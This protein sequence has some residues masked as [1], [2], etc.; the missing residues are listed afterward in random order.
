MTDLLMA[1][2][3]EVNGRRYRRPAR[4]TVVLCFDGFDPAYLEQGLA[5]GLLPALAR[6]RSEGFSALAGAVVPS[7]TNPNNTSIVTGVLPAMHGISG[8][9]YLN[10][11]T[12]QEVMVTDARLMR[13]ETILG[14]MS[15]VGVRVAAVTA[16]DKLRRMLSHNLH[17]ISF[18][19]QCARDATEAENGI[20][21]VEAFVGRSTPD[22]YDPDLSLFVMDAGVRLIEHS[23][24]DLLY[25]SLSDLVQHAHAPGEPES[26]RF[27]AA[28]DS[29]IGRLIELGAVVGVVADHGMNDKANPDGTAR[30]LFLQDEL[31]RRFGNG[32]ARVICP[33]TD[34]FVRHHGSL[35]SY[36]R[37][38]ARNGVD[39]DAMM[40]ATAA[41]PGVELV[42]TGKEAATRFGLPEEFEG[43]LA[44]L[45]DHGTVIGASR[46]E[47]DLSSLAGHR[48]R[49][50]GGLAEQRVPFLLSHPLT[51][52]YA[53][54]ALI[55][56]LRSFDIF[57]FVLNGVAG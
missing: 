52:E 47:H 57:D 25:L 45:G 36:V 54:R 29:R 51:T 33:V 20:G 31:V 48:L 7:F 13:C 26:D 4:P 8:N 10:R 41:M 11:E 39:P 32:A 28:I 40:A 27:H 2:L 38:Y 34:P 22:Q 21:D 37:V 19:S 55:D 30:V 3:V 56:A 46:E 42:L 44:V 50:H 24:V 1:G 6:F 49:S 12:G 5:D 15:Q 14:R 23:M 17:G 43:D 53:D 18:S 9:Y 16:K 35:G